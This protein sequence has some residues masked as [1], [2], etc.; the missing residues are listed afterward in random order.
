MLF[1]FRLPLVL[2]LPLGVDLCALTCNHE[3]EY[4]WDQELS[5]GGHWSFS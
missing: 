4:E 1:C 3:Q 5:G 2:V